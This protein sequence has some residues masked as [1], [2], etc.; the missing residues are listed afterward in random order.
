MWLAQWFTKGLVNAL[1]RSGGTWD[2][3]TGRGSLYVVFQ[4]TLGDLG[5]KMRGGALGGTGALKR[6]VR[7]LRS[8]I[9]NCSSACAAPM[10]NNVPFS[11][12]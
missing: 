2:V 5:D 8:G 10:L 7:L 11:S 12:R 6:W 9:S 4:L 1:E 3:G